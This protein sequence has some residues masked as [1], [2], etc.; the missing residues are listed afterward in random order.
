MSARRC[1]DEVV[2][3]D[4]ICPTG[5]SGVYDGCDACCEAEG[6]GLDTP[7]SGSRKDVSVDIDPTG[8]ENF[9]G[10]INGFFGWFNDRLGHIFYNAILDRDVD[11]CVDVLGGIDDRGVFE[12]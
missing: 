9:A 4:E 12:N 6:V 8:C 5:A 3:G 2:K 10:E 11:Y 7:G 1:G